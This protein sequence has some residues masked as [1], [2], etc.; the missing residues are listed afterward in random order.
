MAYL[1]WVLGTI[2]GSLYDPLFWLLV[3]L[4]GVVAWLPHRWIFLAAIVAGGVWLR[5]DVANGNRELLGLEPYSKHDIMLLA[6]LFPMLA[7]FLISSAL[8]R[9]RSAD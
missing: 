8:A 6:T 5:I 9:R 2:W 1:A 4:A 7:V 3:G